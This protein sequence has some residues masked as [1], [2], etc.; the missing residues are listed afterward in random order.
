M[1]FLDRYLEK[2]LNRLGY[3]KVDQ[4]QLRQALFAGETRPGAEYDVYTNYSNEQFYKLAITNYAI[5]RNIEYLS[6]IIASAT[7]KVERRDPE[8]PEG[9]IDVPAHPFERIAE[10][11]PNPYMSQSFIW[12]YQAMWLLLTGEAYWM[13]VPNGWGELTQMYPLPANRVKPV[14]HPTRFI[15]GFAYNPVDGGPPQILD[16]KN[17]VFHRF[18]N[19]FEYH[20]GLSPLNAY[21]LGLQ[22]STEAQKNDLEDYKNGLGLQQLVS[23]AT[24]TSDRDM[25]QAQAD[26]KSASERG[27]RYK[28]VR[29]GDIKIEAVSQP[30]SE[31]T[32]AI[33]EITEKQADT[34]YG[35]PEGIWSQKSNY[36]HGEKE[37]IVYNGTVWPLLSMLGEDLTVQAVERYYGEQY[38]CAFEDIRIE[39]VELK[40]KEKDSDRQTQT[41]N[42]ARQADGLDPHPDPDV[43]NAPFGAAVQ[44]AVAKATAPTQPMTPI[45]R[46]EGV[47]GEGTKPDGQPAE[48]NPRMALNG[49]QVTAVLNIVTQVKQGLLSR[50]AGLNALE[51]MFN[52]TRQQAERILL[53]EESTKA[54]KPFIP[55]GTF[56]PVDVEAE[57]VADELEARR[58]DYLA[59]WNRVNPE[60]AIETNG[61]ENGR[62]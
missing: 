25:L 29:A 27:D 24:G 59:E 50:E 37:A 9:W 35:L 7:A 12:R 42:E 58:D 8:N 3:N 11:K 49:A 14:P 15:D 4:F 19:P 61:R 41:F 52:F 38:R 53:G 20:R 26:F 45:S 54:A 56:A 60:F 5:Y 28:I 34:I 13:L 55:R 17:V 32:Q 40:L 43:G 30:K 33:Y 18:P 62:N 1:N 46:E 36:K 22:I 44:I 21:L 16:P 39:N 31:H 23:L 6:K 57:A 51:I 10:Y 48:V 47:E 2:A